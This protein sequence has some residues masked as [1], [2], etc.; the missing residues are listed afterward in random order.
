M[1]G[2]VAELEASLPARLPE[3]REGSLPSGV[4]VESAE[5]QVGHGGAPWARKGE[6]V[7]RGEVVALSVDGRVGEGGGRRKKS[8]GAATGNA[9]EERRTQEN[10]NAFTSRIPSTERPTGR[11]LIVIC[12]SSST[13]RT[14]SRDSRTCA[15]PPRT[16]LRAPYRVD[17]DEKPTEGDPLVLDED[18]VLV[19]HG[20]IGRGRYGLG[21]MSGCRTDIGRGGRGTQTS[22]PLL[23]PNGRLLGADASRAFSNAYRKRSRADLAAGDIPVHHAPTEPVAAAPPHRLESPVASEWCWVAGLHGSARRHIETVGKAEESG[24]TSDRPVAMGDVL[25]RIFVPAVLRVWAFAGVG[26]VFK[27]MCRHKCGGQS[28]TPLR[29]LR[30]Y[31]QE[32]LRLRVILHADENRVLDLPGGRSSEVHWA[33]LPERLDHHRLTRNQLMVP[34]ANNAPDL[35]LPS[36]LSRLVES[37]D[38]EE[39]GAREQNITYWE[40]TGSWAELGSA[41]LDGQGRARLAPDHCRQRPKFQHV[42][43]TVFALGSQ[44]WWSGCAVTRLTG[45]AF[46]AARTIRALTNQPYSSMQTSHAPRARHGSPL[47]ERMIIYYHQHIIDYSFLSKLLV[48]V[49]D[50]S[51]PGIVSLHWLH[52]WFSGGTLSSR[53]FSTLD[54][55]F[56]PS[57]SAKHLVD[58][59]PSNFDFQ[60]TATSI[61]DVLAFAFDSSLG[62]ALP[63]FSLFVRCSVNRDIEAHSTPSWR[64][65]ASGPSRSSPHPISDLYRFAIA[66]GQITTFNDGRWGAH[67]YS[68]W[69]QSFHRYFIHLPCIP[70]QGSVYDPGLPILWYDWRDA[71]WIEER[72]GHTRLGRLRDDLLAE[73]RHSVKCIIASSEQCQ[74]GP[75]D[76]QQ[77]HKFLTLGVRLCLDRLAVLPSER[78]VIISLTAHVQRLLLELVGLRVYLREVL[79]RIKEQRDCS[80]DVLD[81]LGAHTSNP[82]TT[83]WLHRAGI[84]VWFQRDRCGDLPVWE[85]VDLTPLPPCFS[86]TPSYPK[87]VLAQQDHSGFLNTPGR[88][89]SAMYSKVHSDLVGKRLPPLESTDDDDSGAPE[90]KRGRP[91][92]SSPAGVAT[93]SGA[94]AQ[95]LAGILA[96]VAPR[97]PKKPS[98]SKAPKETTGSFNVNPFRVFYPSTTVIHDEGW[99]DA[100]RQQGTL[101]QASKSAAYFFPPPWMVDRLD[102]FPLSE[103]KRSRRMLQLVAI[104]AFC[105]VRLFERTRFGGPL[106]VS[107]WRDALWGEYSKDADAA[108]T[109]AATPAAPNRMIA[110]TSAHDPVP[111]VGTSSGKAPKRK[112]P[113]KMTREANRLAAQQAVKQAFA[114]A[115]LPD[116]SPTAAHAYG[117]RVVNIHD[118]A[119][120]E[121]LIRN[122][123]WEAH[124]MN[125]RCELLALDTV[126][127]GSHKSDDLAQW[128]RESLISEVWG[129]AASVHDMHK[130]LLECPGFMHAV[131]YA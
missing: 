2:D 84:P 39:D 54:S 38:I 16:Y 46:S 94:T 17:S 64:A 29:R 128:A 10:W 106:S 130:T 59:T 62:W 72:C 6:L 70:R 57:L 95:S 129:G 3:L 56:R 119:A 125:W 92:T 24:L 27:A 11:L 66:V 82:E 25:K 73:L 18:A 86:S 108:L 68:R 89:L 15:A 80:T 118:V 91:S 43:R 113:A 60:K 87:L 7:G 36:Q 101:P 35:T 44:S 50:P 22:E 49:V 33:L 79:P 45:T 78:G 96:P 71:D 19:G 41:S 5:R 23:L 93:R 120:D 26:E 88:W 116:F 42:C 123:V 103:E 58:S 104:R 126:L 28:R 65:M 14:I 105:R 8:A 102:G 52:T 67:E 53:T 131:Y 115:D 100:L 9:E 81:V 85:V 13:E 112:Q 37:L 69:P 1:V 77:K 114:S 99:T 20:H 121:D 51:Y 4:N 90:S 109:V 97:P 122:L 21:G 12:L 48:P 61:C 83:Q 55:P 30:D 32:I 117:E 47:E 76:A 124:E 75:P 127:T 110:T 107:D 34:S 63:R 31:Q 111:A 74:H 40:F 98:R